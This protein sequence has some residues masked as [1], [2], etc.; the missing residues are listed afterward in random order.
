M[1]VRRTRPPPDGSSVEVASRD[2]TGA[3]GGVAALPVGVTRAF[4]D[5]GSCCGS[6]GDGVSMTVRTLRGEPEGK[7][8]E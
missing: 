1:S 3:D 2:V 4:A 5:G 6:V 7:P 8:R